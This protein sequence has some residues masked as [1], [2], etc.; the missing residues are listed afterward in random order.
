MY[1]I[2]GSYDFE[3]FANLGFLKIKRVLVEGSKVVSV[4]PNLIMKYTEEGEEYV[5]MYVHDG[6]PEGDRFQ[7]P[8][9]LKN[10]ELILKEAKEY[11]LG[12]T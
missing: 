11:G 10:F 7:L 1:K 5:V 8:I 4:N 12:N 2:Y 6:T 3:I 9:S